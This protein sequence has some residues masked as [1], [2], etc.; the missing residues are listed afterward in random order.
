M[1][2]I[3]INKNN[4]S[5]SFSKHAHTYNK[6]SVVQQKVA[7]QL[8]NTMMPF[9]CANPKV[10]EIGCGTGHL[11]NILLDKLKPQKYIVNDISPKMLSQ[12]TPSTA[13]KVELC[14]GDA[15]KIVWPKQIDI[16]TSASTI[17]WF[18]NPLSIIGKSALSINQKGLIAIATYGP[19]TFFQLQ[20]LGI[21]GLHYN[22][23]QEWQ[24]TVED[25]NMTMQIC[26]SQII[27]QYFQSAL[28]LMRRLQ[29]T[30]VNATHNKLS[31]KQMYQLMHNYTQTYQ[32]SNGL[33]LSYEVFVFVITK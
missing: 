25:N 18:N 10:F 9:C 17:Q 14:I 19:K 20:N 12:L 24:K 6:A 23:L 30:G 32:T 11:T 7:Q 3:D 31:T 27:T 21:E 4:I 33:P 13:Q 1:E 22:S 28:E 26:S 29:Q 5:K 2:S 16:I 15:E 8:A